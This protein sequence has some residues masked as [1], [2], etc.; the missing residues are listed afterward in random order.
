MPTAEARIRTDRASRYL[1][2][3][4]RHL[5]HL[6]HLSHRPAGPDRTDPDHAGSDHADHAGPDHTSPAGAVRQPPRIRSVDWSDSDGTIDF[7]VG[8]LTLHATPDTL[9]LHV[10]A[11]NEQA[12]H[13]LQHAIA[14]RVEKIGRRDR[15]AVSW[16]PPGASEPDPATTPD[17]AIPSGPAAAIRRPRGM[18]LLAAAAVL[19]VG[20]HIAVGTAV[21][22]GARWMSWAAGT[23]LVI[24]AIKLAAIA[25]AGLTL[26]HHIPHRLPRR[27]RQP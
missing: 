25:L 1:A 12:L 4:C 17:Q 24:V 21:L 19:A 7:G 15:I 2:Q 13:R 6:R 14:D 8:Q 11:A 3:L 27:R 16:L 20:I 9:V 10:E 23:V 18:I 5:S 26:R 22:T